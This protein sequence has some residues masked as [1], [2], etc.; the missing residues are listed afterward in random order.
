[1]LLAFPAL[2][3]RS[4][5][6]TQTVLESRDGTFE[7]QEVQPQDQ[8]HDSTTFVVSKANPDKKQL[9]MT[10]PS[11]WGNDWYCSPDSKW[12]AVAIREVHKV[13]SMRLFRRTEGFEF[14]QI[15]DFAHR[16]WAS[17][18][19]KRK[20]TR[21][22]EGIIDFVNWSPDSTRL[23][24]ALRGPVHGDEDDKLWFVAW[25][26][27]FNVQTQKFEYTRYLDHW[28][29][30]VFKSV[31][32]DDYA[33]RMALAPVSAEPLFD[34]VSEE[35]W[36]QRQTDADRALN[37]TY[38]QALAKLG[39]EDAATIRSQQIVWIKN[40]DKIAD[41]FAKQGTP[42]NP[43]LRRLQSLVDATNARTADLK[44]DSLSD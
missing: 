5:T 42:P 41:E 43:T 40:R 3:A 34:T 16:A 30:G 39:S 38:R 24:I 35:E 25:S 12:L 19:T 27:Y 11:F 29:A 44:R 37:E 15:K 26:V 9:L 1:M 17:I 23:L 22:E 20:Y 13:S 2:I 4:E 33:D 14:D 28:D 36:K 8:D 32:A 6:T 7:I 10:E 31:S 21:G 18:S